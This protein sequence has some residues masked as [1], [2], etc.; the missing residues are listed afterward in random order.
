MNSEAKPPRPERDK[1]DESLRTERKN[2][3]HVIADGRTDVE[4]HADAVVERAREHADAVLEA[5]RDKAD[6][7]LDTAEPEPEAEAREVVAQERAREDEVVQ[8]ER[9]AADRRLHSERLE[10]ARTLAR[11]L[12]LEREKT[13][14]YLLTE[15]ARSDDALAH[16]DDFMGMVSHDLRNLLSGIVMNAMLLSEEATESDEGRRTVAGMKRIERYAARMKRLIGDL[17]DVVSIDAGKLA[18][19]PQP[20]DASALITEAV[21]VFAH[22]ASQGG[23]TLESRTIVPAVMAQLDHERMLQVLANLISNALKFTPRGGSVVVRGER[24]GDELRFSVSDTGAGVPGDMLEAVFERFTQVGKNDQ[25]G[26]GL[27]LYISKCIIDAHGGKIWVESK[28]GEGSAFHFTLPVSP[29]PSS[30][31]ATGSAA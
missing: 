22:A 23:I 9:A 17:V 25:R 5:A 24:V 3:D 19:E 28:L 11:L 2:S 27:G 7:R 10:Q 6:Q 31:G 21:D 29:A 18:M 16:R 13:D 1:T 30:A 15:R 20:V 26:L 8:Q 4:E 14:R 12:P